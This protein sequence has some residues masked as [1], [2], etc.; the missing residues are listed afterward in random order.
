MSKLVLEFAV[1][2]KYSQLEFTDI[3]RAI[4]TQ[5]NTL[6]EGKLAARYRADV[7]AP[8]GSAMAYAV[9]DITWD[10]SPTV[11]G[12]IAPGVAAAY[13]RVGWICTSDGKPG[14][15][16]EMRFATGT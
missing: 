14:T 9:G 8:A 7:S 13:V 4:C 6:S 3:I 10:S 1:P 16:V 11:R 5:V 2:D 12:S 15:H